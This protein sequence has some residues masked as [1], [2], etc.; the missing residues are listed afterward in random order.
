MDA[1]LTAV[2]EH[3]THSMLSHGPGELVTH[4]TMYTP[5]TNGWPKY[6]STPINSEE[7]AH[8]YPGVSQTGPGGIYAFL[9]LGDGPAQDLMYKRSATPA[10][11]DDN[12]LQIAEYVWLSMP[13]T[14]V[15][16]RQDDGHTVYRL[17][18]PRTA[19]FFDYV[20]YQYRNQENIHRGEAAWNNGSVCSTFLAFAHHMAGKGTI[21]PATYDHE[22]I[23]AAGNALYSR[24][25]DECSTN[26]SWLMDVGSTLTCFEGICDDAARQTRNCMARGVCDSDSSSHWDA[27][28]NDPNSI[29]VSTSPDRLAGLSGHPFEGPE[30]SVWAYDEGTDVQ[31]N[32]GGDVYGCW[33]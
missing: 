14:A 27:V 6:C 18:H 22:T 17:A 2:G 9:Y 12:G 7:L 8:G 15:D 13:Y 26:T 32:S 10:G 25:E 24:V 5:G 31:W 30:A 33:F 11:V 1:V 3:Y 28:R 21:E 4:S 29:A 16:S 20:L 23:V 19:A